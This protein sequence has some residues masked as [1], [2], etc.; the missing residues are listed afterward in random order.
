MDNKDDLPTEGNP[1]NATRPSP[2]FATSNPRSAE[3]PP[4]D[5]LA[6]VCTSVLNLAKRAR[7]AIKWE[8]VALFFC[9]R[10]ISSSMSLIL[11]TSPMVL[12][13]EWRNQACVEKGLVAGDVVLVAGLG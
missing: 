10:L 9:V 8:L 2:L 6:P 1:I 4:A 12:K 13:I 3:L 11:S 5:E 7:N